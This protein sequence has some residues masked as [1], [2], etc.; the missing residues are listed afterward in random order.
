MTQR[1]FGGPNNRAKAQRRMDTNDLMGSIATVDNKQATTI[2][3]RT[4]KQS[5]IDKFGNWIRD[6][7]NAFLIQRLFK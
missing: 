6:S 2:I 7:S 5:G 4:M 3:V 1:D